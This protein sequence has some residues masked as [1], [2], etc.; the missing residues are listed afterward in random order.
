MFKKYL[1]VGLSLTM[2]ALGGCQAT[3]SSQ[4]VHE[5]A[6]TIANKKQ[7][8]KT[9]ATL[10]K[11]TF[12]SGDNAYLEVNHNQS[13]LDVRQWQTERIKYGALDD[14][15]RTTTNT[16]FLSK[17]TLGHSNTRHR[18]TWQPTG[19]HNQPVMID[20]QRVFPESRG[21]LIAYAISFNFNRDG[22]FQ[23]GE[24][25]SSNNPKNLATQTVFSN[26]RTMQIFEDQ[27]RQALTQNKK[28]IYQVTTVFRGNELMP[29]GYW[30]QAIST[31]KKL[32]FNAYVWNVQPKMQ[33]DYATGR[34]R[35]DRTMTVVDQY[36][37]NAYQ[38]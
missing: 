32:N 18:Q 16:A 4:P 2:L 6:P 3:Q 28:V 30:V 1:V 17:E 12:K 31:D 7:V 37:G 26:Q 5:N 27:V 36:A 13:T 38:N 23:K 10:A 24:L 29:R 34:G 8:A 22:V 15:N 21:H 20:G 25:G 35:Y 33:F 19:W 14:L 11:K 9:A